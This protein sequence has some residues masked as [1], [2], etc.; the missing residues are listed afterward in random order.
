MRKSLDDTPPSPLP[1]PLFAHCLFL[2]KS[3]RERERGMRN[4]GDVSRGGKVGREG[5]A[6]LIS[7]APQTRAEQEK[8]TGR[9]G[10]T[11]SDAARWRNT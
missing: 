4:G 2:P 10:M 7:T 6:K 11:P 5:E 3:E 9:A 8:A 1:P